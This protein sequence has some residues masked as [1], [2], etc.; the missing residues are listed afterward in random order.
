MSEHEVRRDGAAEAAGSSPT[1]TVVKQLTC[2]RCPLGCQLD[3][4][5]D[6][7]GQVIEISG[8]TCGRGKKYGAEEAV[9]PMRTVTALVNV[10]GR[11]MPLSVKTAAP[12]P[13]AR[14]GACLDE[15][16]GLNVEAPVAIGDVIR[17]D[18]CGTGVDVVATKNVK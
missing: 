11:R 10:T 2:I 16:R 12:I 4:T 7:Q 5:L 8:Y 6:T 18:V 14:I 9:C 1:G 15:L 13:K 3:V 17:A